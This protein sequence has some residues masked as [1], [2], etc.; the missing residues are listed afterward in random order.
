VDW[1]HEDQDR[2]K[3]WAV[4]NGINHLRPPQGEGYFFEDQ[5]ECCLCPEPQ[6]MELQPEIT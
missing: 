3:E 5:G 1:I 6:C 4:L 2:D